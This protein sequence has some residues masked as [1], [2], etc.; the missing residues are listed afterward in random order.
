[1]NG[2]QLNEKVVKLSVTDYGNTR[3]KQKTFGTQVSHGYIDDSTVSEQ[4][5]FLFFAKTSFDKRTL[6]N[7][8]YAYHEIT[9]SFRPIENV[10]VWYLQKKL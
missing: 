1:M 4:L 8:I 6:C 7:A 5:L 10:F 3:E 9:F 2:K